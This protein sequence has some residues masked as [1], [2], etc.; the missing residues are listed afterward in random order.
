MRVERRHVA[1]VDA[2]KFLDID[3]VKEAHYTT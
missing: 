3:F 2:V 1:K